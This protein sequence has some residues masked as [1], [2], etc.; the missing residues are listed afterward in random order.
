VVLVSLLSPIY[1]NVLSCPDQRLRAVVIRAVASLL[2]TMDVMHDTSTEEFK[3]AM[4]LYKTN[5]SSKMSRLN[6]GKVRTCPFLVY[7]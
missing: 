1:H 2:H 4:G 5:R 7:T 3:K 6:A